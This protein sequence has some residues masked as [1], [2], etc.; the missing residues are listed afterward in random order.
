VEL[1]SRK[2]AIA[3]GLPRYF[4]GKPCANGHVAERL[5]ANY[6]CIDCQHEANRRKAPERLGR[7]KSWREQNKEHVSTYAS[8]VRPWAKRRAAKLNALPRWF[9][10]LDQFV[11]EECSTLAAERERV[12]GFP[13]QVDHM[14]PLQATEAC[15]LHCAHNLQVIPAYLNRG[16]GNKM[17]FTKPF[18]W[19]HACAPCAPRKSGVPPR[20]N[21]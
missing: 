6:W 7:Q 3:A 20:L 8:T 21:K 10:E 5:A 11:T 4:T 19:L 17:I 14:I 9:G 16:K 1:I 2:D 13:W 12:T 18:E 15:G